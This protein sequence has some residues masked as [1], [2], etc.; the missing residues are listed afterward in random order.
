MIRNKKGFVFIETIITVVVLSASLIIIYSAY[1]S[2]ISDEKTRLYYDDPAYIHR[3]YFVR[4]FLYL[5]SNIE[6][7]KDYVFNNS[8]ITTIGVGFDT[9]FT[10]EQEDAGMRQSLQILYDIYNIN[11]MVIVDG[12]TAKECLIHPDASCKTAYQFVS[13][14]MAGYIKTLNLLENKYYLV[15]EYTEKTNEEGIVER[16]TPSIDTRCLS[17]YTVLTV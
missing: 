13:V 10:Q 9:M 17:F 7:I 6:Y 4:E 14:N 12:A 16:C 2:A 15:I 8:Y 5:N 1:S 3:S 11:Q